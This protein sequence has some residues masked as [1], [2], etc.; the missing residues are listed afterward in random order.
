M[1]ILPQGAELYHAD[2][3]TNMTKLTATFRNFENAPKTHTRAHTHTH[4]H[5]HTHIYLYTHPRLEP[6]FRKSRNIPQ[7]TL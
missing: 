3:R 1:K 5:T 6:R 7:P 4:T 2:T